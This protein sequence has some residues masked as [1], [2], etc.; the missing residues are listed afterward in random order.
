[1]KENV[2]CMSPGRDLDIEVALN[3]MDFIWL[4]HLLQFSAELAVKWLGTPADIEGSGGV[5]IA[6]TKESEMVSL[7]LRENFD[8]AVPHYSTEMG[9]AQQVV[10][11]MESLGYTYISEKKIEQDRDL[12]YVT[13]V[14]NGI[15]FG[16]T[17]GHHSEA[18]AIVKTA[19]VTLL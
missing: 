4:K 15:D 13:F 2:L 14:K 3:V 18:E 17:V 11:H 16:T 6:L 7:K 5:Y 8:E 10:V 1:M 9:A 12:Y 19:L